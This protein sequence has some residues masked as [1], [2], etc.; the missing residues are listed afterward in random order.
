M[1]D[2]VWCG[3]LCLHISVTFCGQRWLLTIPNSCTNSLFSGHTIH[4]GI[5]HTDQ[6]FRVI[7]VPDGPSRDVYLENPGIS[8]KALGM[9]RRGILEILGTPH[10]IPEDSWM[11]EFSNRLFCTQWKIEYTTCR[12][13][14][15]WP[16]KTAKMKKTLCSTISGIYINVNNVV[17]YL[18]H[19]LI[20]IF[21]I[22]SI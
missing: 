4:T 8:G 19:V 2:H 17:P 13:C 7:L 21:S 9:S 11:D 6:F 3:V 5:L 12:T 14:L 22:H 10:E 15:R 20:D 18:W 16:S 1:V